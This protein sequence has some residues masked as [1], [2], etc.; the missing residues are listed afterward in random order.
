[1]VLLAVYL[2]ATVVS[3]WVAFFSMAHGLLV[4]AF[5]AVLASVVIVFTGSR[6]FNNSSVF[7]PWW[8][9]APP[10]LAVLFIAGN[11]GFVMSDPGTGTLSIHDN[12]LRTIAILSLT[13]IYG[14]RLTWNFLR[15]WP[16]L[17]HE[18]W[19]YVDFRKSTGSLYWVV[20]F[21]GIHF[22]P[23]MMVLAGSLSLWVALAAPVND[24]GYLDA[25]ALVV[26]AGAIFLEAKSDSELRAFVA[27]KRNAGKTM[28][29]GLWS[30][31][32]HPNYL[33]EISFWWGLY[34]FALSANPSLWW[35]IAGPLV[36][37]LMFIFISIPMIEKRMLIRKENY[38]EYRKRVS[39]LIPL[40]FRH[41]DHH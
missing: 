40:N 32:R 28:D 14:I 30:L 2:F 21:L 15:G 35:V 12:L 19:R 3:S 7:D 9:V 16:G 37:T 17:T 29:R 31:S 23:S 8:S 20:S 1:M 24:I 36:I 38:K 41:P 26:T 4:A 10:L 27:D 5:S 18:D 11:D 6:I 34:L 39:M 33:G 13:F 22:F 25:L